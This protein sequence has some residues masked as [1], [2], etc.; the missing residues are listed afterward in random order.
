MGVWGKLTTEPIAPEPIGATVTTSPP[1]AGQVAGGGVELAVEKAT[2]QGD[3]G[4]PDPTG[5]AGALAAALLGVAVVVGIAVNSLELT[6]E[7]FDPAENAEA[8]FALF[9]GFYV[10]AQ[11]IERLMEF[12]APLLPPWAITEPAG[13]TAEA[14]AARAAQVKAD[15]AKLVL[16]VASVLGVAVSGFFG[17]FFLQAIGMQVSPTVDTI[18][19][20]ITIAAGTKP[21]HDFISSLQN[22]DNPTTATAPDA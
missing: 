4:L 7:A 14:K 10:G 11:V 12:V 16:G 9:A 22:K 8:N 13:D 2:D 18:L 17:L 15:R 1:E 19:T 20:G 21:L 3:K 5:Q 6:A